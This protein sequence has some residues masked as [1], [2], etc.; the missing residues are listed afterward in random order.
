MAKVQILTTP[1]CSSC[2]AVEKM[3]DRMGVEYELIDVTGHPE[4]FQKYPIM[5]APGIVIDGRLEFV[6]V[7][8]ERELAGKLKGE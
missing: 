5:S 6:G 3:L 7:P 8:K 2:V 1:S 4:I